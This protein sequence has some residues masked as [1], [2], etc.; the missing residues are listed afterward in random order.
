MYFNTT[1]WYT[2]STY[3]RIYLQY[4]DTGRRE[5]ISVLQI[6]SSPLLLYKI[7]CSSTSFLE[8]AKQFRFG[9]FFGYCF[10]LTISCVFWACLVFR[11]Y[12]MQGKDI[13]DNTFNHHLYDCLI[14]IYAFCPLVL[15]FV[16]QT[17]RPFL[18]QFIY[19]SSKLH[20]KEPIL[21]MILFYLINSILLSIAIV[22]YL[23]LIKYQYLVFMYWLPPHKISILCHIYFIIL[24]LGSLWHFVKT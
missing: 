2:Y 24:E 14:V 15:L 4:L 21:S 16:I 12:S 3:L 8:Y 5:R 11:V 18:F 13:Q 20:V 1:L 22:S 6:T 7:I 9:F 19:H 10:F 23:K 17:Q